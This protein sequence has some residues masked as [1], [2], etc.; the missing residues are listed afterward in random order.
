MYIYLISCYTSVL[1]FRK[2][3]IAVHIIKENHAEIRHE[4][5][6]ECTLPPYE[7]TSLIEFYA[8]NECYIASLLLLTKLF[9]YVNKN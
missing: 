3:Q 6:R 5:F 2:G 4:Q 9:I 1:C 8:Y 7:H